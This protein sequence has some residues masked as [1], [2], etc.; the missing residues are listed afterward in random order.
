VTPRRVV[1]AMALLLAIAAPSFAAEEETTQQ[2]PA[3]QQTEDWQFEV[4]PYAWIPGTFGTIEVKGHTAHA[5]VTMGDVLTL[6][7][8]GDAFTVG[9][10]FL[11]RY[12]PWNTFAFLDSYGGFLNLP[13]SQTIPTRFCTVRVS[14]TARLK[15]VITEFAIGYE[16]GRWSMPQR[17]RPISLGL[18]LGMRYTHLGTDLEASVGVVNGVKFNG[19]VSAGFN[20]ASPMI[21]VRW[22][23]PLLDRLSLDFRGDLGGLPSGSRLTWGLVGDVRYWPD[24]SLFSAQPWLEAGYRVV[25]YEHEFGSNNALN[26]Q[27]RGVLL[28]VGFAF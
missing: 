2:Q 25:A 15:P 8:H 7:W 14:S 16:L 28:G 17:L 6:L 19:N 21:G 5:D 10:Y 26:L 12:D 24:L 9:G 27:L 20:P 4:M 23:V 22:E 1:G 11:A 3:E 18:Y 13:V